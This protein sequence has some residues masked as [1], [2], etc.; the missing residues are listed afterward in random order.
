MSEAAIKSAQSALKS[1]NYKALKEAFVSNLNGGT[2]SEIVAV[3]MTMP[4]SH[5]GSLVHAHIPGTCQ[6]TASRLLC[7][8]GQYY[9]LES[10]FSSLCR[11]RISLLIGSSIALP[12]CL[13]LPSIPAPLLSSM[14]YYFFPPCLHCFRKAHSHRQP[15]DFPNLPL[16]NPHSHQV[17]QPPPCQ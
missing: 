14:H 7:W 15:G 12:Y 10:T 9:S 13:Q 8:F 3:T 17:L 11:L 4:V 2:I 6:L 16:L 5:S 1:N